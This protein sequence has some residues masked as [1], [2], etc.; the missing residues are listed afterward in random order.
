MRFRDAILVGLSSREAVSA[1]ALQRH[2]GMG[3]TAG[4]K[5]ALERFVIAGR[6][7]IVHRGTTGSLH[8][9]G[10]DPSIYR[11]KA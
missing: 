1:R 10:N 7:E 6:V 2:I 4:V 9:I 8:R 5:D 3:T 11:L